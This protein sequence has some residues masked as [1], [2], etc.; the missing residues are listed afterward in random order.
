MRKR[1]F[2]WMSGFILFSV[3]QEL[4]PYFV[5]NYFKTQ[6]NRIFMHW[7]TLKNAKK[8]KFLVNFNDHR[9]FHEWS[10]ETL[11]ERMGGTQIKYQIVVVLRC[12]GRHIIRNTSSASKHQHHILKNLMHSQITMTDIWIKW[13]H[14]LSTRTWLLLHYILNP[15]QRRISPQFILNSF[16]FY[17]I[18]IIYWK[19]SQYFSLLI[20]LI[21]FYQLVIM[22]ITFY[23]NF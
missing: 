3:I 18:I 11:E 22:I 10:A 23:C 15:W 1:S 6:T 12:G 21:S 8:I 4:I 13:V 16:K 14:H 20:V 5:L 19:V 9:P 17:T 7:K 2:L